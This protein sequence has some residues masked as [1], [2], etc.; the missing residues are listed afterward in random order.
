[1]NVLYVHMHVANSIITVYVHMNVE[2]SYSLA[3]FIKFLNETLHNFWPIWA[4]L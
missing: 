3:L 4:F 1:M 2:E